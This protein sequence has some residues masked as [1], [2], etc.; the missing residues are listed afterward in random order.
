MRFAVVLRVSFITKI[1]PISILSSK[2]WMD[3]VEARLCVGAGVCSLSGVKNA[4][5]F[6]HKLKNPKRNEDATRNFPTFSR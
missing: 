3:P 1:R 5:E 2:M 4:P 6:V